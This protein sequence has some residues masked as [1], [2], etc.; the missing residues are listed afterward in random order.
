[1]DKWEKEDIER[2]LDRLEKQ[3]GRL[4]DQIHD[5]WIALIKSNQ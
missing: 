4:S 5:L 3:V 2:R 1:M